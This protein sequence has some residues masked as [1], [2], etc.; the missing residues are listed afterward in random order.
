MYN[1]QNVFL[2]DVL[3][4]AYLYPMSSRYKN[5][6]HYI[7]KYKRRRFSYF[8]YN[9]SGSTSSPGRDNLHVEN[10]KFSLA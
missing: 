6:C 9:K 8:K 10:L 2:D 3:L 4:F 1:N 7:L 5:C